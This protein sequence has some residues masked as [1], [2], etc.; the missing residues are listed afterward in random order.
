M[1]ISR[2]EELPV[3][4]DARN[5][6]KEV[7]RITNTGDFSKDY[8]LKDQVRSSSV[9]MMSNIAEGFESQTTKQFIRYLYIAKGSCG[10]F[11]SQLYVSLDVGYLNE[12]TANKLIAEAESISKQFSGLINYL[13][14]Y[15]NKNMIREP[16]SF[17][18]IIQKYH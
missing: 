2:F 18:Q 10:E 14:G 17:F 16:E 7:Y 6:T 12:A 1:K 3:W 15:E 9:S 13:E 5:L 8:R 4:K 11:R